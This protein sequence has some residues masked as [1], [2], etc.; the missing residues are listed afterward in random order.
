[1]LSRR[2]FLL[3]SAG[4]AGGA[5]VVGWL[6]LRPDD[7]LDGSDDLK[8]AADHVPLNGW[9]IIGTDDSVTVVMS[10]SEMGQGI[11]TGAAMLLAE[12][13]GADWSKVRVVQAPIDAIY[14]NR[15]NLGAGLPYRPD[16]QREHVRLVRDVLYKAS[17][18]IGSMVTGG[19]TSIVD[20]WEPMR[21]AGASARE[22]LC[23]AAAR[24]WSV[25]VGECVVKAGTVLHAFSGKT[26][27]FGQLATQ[28]SK[29]SH[30]SRPALKDPSTY[31]LIGRSLHRIEAPGKLNGSLRF[32]IDVV[33]AELARDVGTG[34]PL[35]LLY[36]SV[37]MCPTLGGRLKSRD[38]KLTS[39][40]GVHKWVPV[41]GFGGGTGGIAAIADNPFIA[42]RALCDVR[43][44]WDHGPAARLNTA[45]VIKTLTQALDDTGNCKLHEVGDAEAALKHGKVLHMHYE[46]PYLAHGAL[47]PINCTVL[48]EKRHATVWVSTQVPQ[49]ARRAVAEALNF[50]HDQVT[51]HERFPGGGFGRRLEA[52]YVAQAAAIAAQM[53]GRAVQTIWS[54]PEDM[55]HDFYR[56][57]CVARFSGAL[58]ADGN[59]SA[60]SAVTASQSVTEQVLPRSYGVPEVIARH[61][62]DGTMGEG[63]FDQAYECPNIMIRHSRVDLPIPIGYWRSV[64]HSHQ[65]F[66]VESFLDE[67]AAAA[68]KDPIEFRLGML[69]KKEHARHA[70]VLHKLV[71]FAGWKKPLKWKDASGTEFGRGMAMH[72]C[73][74]SVVAQVA[75]VR[76]DATDG[77]RVTRVFC[78]IDCGIAVNP[79]MV[80]QQME[81]GIVFGLSAAMQQAITIRNGQVQQHYFSEVPLI[82]MESCPDIRTHVMESCEKVPHGVGEAGTPPIA[83]A[84]ANAV[85]AL[86]GKSEKDRVRALPLVAPPKLP[87]DEALWEG[88]RWCKWCKSL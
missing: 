82:D 60:W 18:Y 41:D 21:H 14:I 78:V 15:D 39:V 13:L 26:A 75:E 43:V 65:A 87:E 35:E 63:G 25:P 1:M 85:F 57:A 31:T 10:K 73:F 52:D 45:D 16:D 64:G 77:Y 74:G 49:V 47:E 19:S 17:R 55:T 76:K 86:K 7:R 50:G 12:E 79:D 36:A 20:L 34:R 70:A 2:S 24:Q 29:L 83:P 40:P 5:L 42:M 38:V 6:A 54:R 62:P 3:G 56:P 11:H 8:A 88:D 28:A 23:T 53:E 72:E 32:G 9:V 68:G 46:V 44:E 58:D 37:L 22:M 67:M 61:L 48:V 51:I 84:L 27:T 66:F 4:A 33:K 30:P 80:K 69:K 59:L 81:S 71:E